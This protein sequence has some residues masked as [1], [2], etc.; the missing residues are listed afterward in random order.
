MIP[1]EDLPHN[2]AGNRQRTK[3]RITVER[4]VSRGR[5][6]KKAARDRRGGAR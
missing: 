5:E 6:R 3:Q 1:T 4:A 2:R